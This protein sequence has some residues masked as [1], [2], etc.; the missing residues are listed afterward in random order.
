MGVAGPAASSGPKSDQVVSLLE[1]IFKALTDAEVRYVVVGGVAVVLHG[2]P[3]M[4][5]DL[6][7]ALDL[8]PVHLAH[9]L[10]VISGFGFEPALP[11]TMAQFLDPREREHWVQD[12]NMT[13]FAMRH[14]DSPLISLDVF[15]SNPIPFADLWR[16]ASE[17]TLTTTRVRIASIDHLIEMKTLAGRRKDLDDIEHLQAIRGFKE[18]S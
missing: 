6:D 11:V 1:P 13:V 10:E 5:A 12:R 3:R 9:A 15:T 18:G 4:T 17:A 7:L 16:D 8:D 14:P 2:H